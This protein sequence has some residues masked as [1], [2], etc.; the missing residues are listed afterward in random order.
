M[1]LDFATIVGLILGFSLIV[2][3]IMI[4]GDILAF[5]DLPAILIVLGGTFS[6]TMVCFSIPEVM[7]AQGVILKTMAFK[8]IDES[9]QAKKMIEIAQKARSGGVLAIQSD[10]A[11]LTDDFVKQAF[12][13][14]VDGI[15]PETIETVMQDD[16]ESMLD[17]HQKSIS[18][19][20]K[21]A[22][23]APAM[24]LVG[25]LIGLVQMLGNLSDPDK[26]GPAMA[27]A[28]L[29]TLYG[30]L[31]AN[32]VFMPLA[33]KLERNSLSEYQLRRI[34]MS[35]VLSTVKQENPRQLEVL[36]NAILPPAKRIRVF[37]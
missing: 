21:S 34:Y 7:R 10:I 2:S 36:I 14:A 30:A 8:Q 35:S 17:R 6:I 18:V 19:L 25:T 31:L 29:T 32:L 20:R 16:T 12:Q 37:D 33:S 9:A 1:K 15:N 3:A 24:G 28:L 23:V 27:V 26:I 11:D 5:I 22:E 13:M 4:G